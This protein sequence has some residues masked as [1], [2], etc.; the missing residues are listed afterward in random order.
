MKGR[1]ATR[2]VRDR[3]DRPADGKDSTADPHLS[4]RHHRQVTDVTEATDIT[5]D[6]RYDRVGNDYYY[7]RRHHRD[8]NERGVSTTMTAATSETISTITI[9]VP[10]ANIVARE[11][12]RQICNGLKS[13]TISINPD[14]I[15]TAR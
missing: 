11:Y 6:D 7:E 2:E 14:R 8:D 10:D 13:H 5:T 3:R 1:K 4:L 9:I 12:P 15:T